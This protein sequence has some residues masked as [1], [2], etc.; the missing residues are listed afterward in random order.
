MQ[1]RAWEG[2]QVLELQAFSLEYLHDHQHQPENEYVTPESTKMYIHP[3]GIQ[4]FNKIRVTQ[5]QTYFIPRHTC[6]IGH[7]K[8]IMPAR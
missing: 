2:L 5:K 7:P 8:D 1:L 3:Q 6:C 4:L